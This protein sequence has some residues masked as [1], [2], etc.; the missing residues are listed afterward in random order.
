MSEVT[1]GM[2]VL[3]LRPGAEW[4]MSDDDVENMIWYT[5]GVEPLTQAEVT[6]EVAR[7]EQ[8]ALDE[9]AEKEALRQSAM[10]KLT[11]LGLTVDEVAAITN[12]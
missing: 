9:A 4:T 11:V 12:E 2:A 3:S 5:E 8:A 6:A 7:L 10:Q 1:V